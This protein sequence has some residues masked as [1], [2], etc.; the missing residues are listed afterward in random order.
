MV[1]LDRSISEQ[2]ERE[3]IGKRREGG[4]ESE[5]SSDKRFD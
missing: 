2:S 4:E 1:G 5:A 3:F